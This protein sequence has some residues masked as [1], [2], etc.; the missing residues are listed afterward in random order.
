MASVLAHAGEFDILTGNDADADRHGIVTPDDGLM[1][2]NHYLAVAIE[3]LFAHRPNWRADAAIGKTLVSSSMIDRVAASLGRRLWEVPVGFKWFVPGL[4]DG[5]VGFGGEES[6]GA[7]FLRF[8]GSVWTT[9]KD[10][11]LLCLLASEIRAVTGKSPSELYAS[12]VERFGDPAYER[13]DAAASAAQ[14]AALGKLDGDAISATELAGEA[15]TAKLSHA[16]GNDAAIGG[17]KVTTENAWFAAR[18]SGTEDVYKI[19]AESFEGPEH[20][21]AVQAAAKQIVDAALGA[22]EHETA[23]SRAG[24]SAVTPALRGHLP[25]DQSRGLR[26]HGGCCRLPAGCTARVGA[27]TRPLLRW[28]DRPVCSRPKAAGL[29]RIPAAW[30]ASSR[31]RDTTVESARRSIGSRDVDRLRDLD[32]LEGPRS[33]QA[34][35]QPLTALAPHRRRAS[36]ARRAT[37]DASATAGATARSVTHRRPRDHPS[38]AR[39]A[40]D[41]PRRPARETSSDGARE[42]VRGRRSTGRSSWG[43]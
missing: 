34:R 12:L 11:I 5:S 25:G 42:G 6:A 26:A 3:Y 16:P 29:G 40:R 22:L 8:D 32:R 4:I 37:S 13:T 18:P 7:S 24:E 10:G 41:R 2:P 27:V 15:I 36:S 38:G 39:R 17:L 21:K 35:R 28:R 14:K 33:T 43:S 30:G 1:N 9:D 19:Y 20:L 23:E 31:D